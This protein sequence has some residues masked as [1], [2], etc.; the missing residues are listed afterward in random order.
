[1]PSAAA[2]QGE[3][4]LLDAL[5]EWCAEGTRESSPGGSDGRDAC[6]AEVEAAMQS[7]LGW[8][9]PYLLTLTLT[10]GALRSPRRAA[11]GGCEGSGELE[12]D[13]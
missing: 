3:R 4:A 11:L 5:A 13:M 7:K 8:W 9:V 10:R 6:K 2:P 12:I 1:M